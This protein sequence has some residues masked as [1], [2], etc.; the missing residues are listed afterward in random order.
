M[1]RVCLSEDLE[2]P[3]FSP[4]EMLDLDSALQKLADVSERA[5]RVVEYRFFSGLSIDDVA[6]VLGVSPR[7]VDGDWEFARAW[8]SRAIGRE[9]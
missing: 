2:E 9:T 5:A 6:D 1:T 8:L 3:S 4:L 7:T